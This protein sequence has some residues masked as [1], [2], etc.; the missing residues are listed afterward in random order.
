MTEKPLNIL[1]RPF[2][3]MDRKLGKSQ[4]SSYPGTVKWFC[5]ISVIG[6]PETFTDWIREVK[7]PLFSHKQHTYFPH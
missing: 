4:V 3:G 2:F 6:E 5:F 1:S 7:F